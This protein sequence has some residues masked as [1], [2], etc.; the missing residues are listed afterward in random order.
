[1]YNI[2]FSLFVLAFYFCFKTMGALSIQDVS[3]LLFPT[4]PMNV[5]NNF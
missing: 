4:I 2:C 1:M 3:K 5:I